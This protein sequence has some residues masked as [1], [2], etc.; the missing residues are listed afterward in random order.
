MSLRSALMESDLRGFPKRRG[1]VRDVYDLGDRLVLVAT[2]R[3]SAFDWILPAGI[4]DK[5]RVLTALSLFWF[6]RFQVPNHLIDDRVDR[7]PTATDD[8]RSEL[9]GRVMIVKKAHVVPFECVVRGYLSGSGWKEYRDQGT[10]CGVRLASGLKESD[11]LD[12]PIFTPATKAE[13][14]HD[15]NVS[16]DHM[17]DVLGSELA[18]RLRD[19]SVAVY[20]QGAEFARSRGLILADTKF[21]WGTDWKTGELM[22]VDEVLTPDSSRYWDASGYRPGGAQPSFDKQFVRDWLETTG[23]DKASPPPLLPDEIVNRTR[24]KYIQAYKIVTGNAFPWS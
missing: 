21:E 10:V 18:E 12:P 24:D 6:K 5:G 20:T 22:L 11:A 14:G 3:I 2:D 19:Q 7:L 1:K 4:P 16:F 8:D 13:T 23:W 15:E 17:A 9:E